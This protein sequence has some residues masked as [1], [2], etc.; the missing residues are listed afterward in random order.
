MAQCRK[1]ENE[2]SH[3]ISSAFGLHGWL[4][5]ERYRGF[6][7]AFARDNAERVQLSVR[8]AHNFRPVGAFDLYRVVYVPVASVDRYILSSWPLGSTVR[9]E[10]H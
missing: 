4:V 3:V 2:G 7:F 9:T 10:I 6:S 1:S 5:L 8:Y